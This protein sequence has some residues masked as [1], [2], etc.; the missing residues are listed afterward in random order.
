M[1]AL[2]LG[3]IWEKPH[4]VRTHLASLGFGTNSFLG[5]VFYFDNF[6]SYVAAAAGCTDDT[7]CDDANACNGSESCVAGGCVA[8]TPVTCDDGSECTSDSCD[9]GTGSCSFNAITCNDGLSCSVDSCDPALGCQ[10]DTSACNAC[11][12]KGTACSATAKCC[13]GNCKGGACR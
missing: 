5:N 9:P 6:D 13:G 11:G 4:L 7:E 12:T 2:M 1:R 3:S 8:G 10:Y